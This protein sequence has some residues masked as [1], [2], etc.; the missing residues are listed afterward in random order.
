MTDILVTWN[1]ANGQQRFYCVYYK[2]GNNKFLDGRFRTFQ[3][4]Y[5]SCGHL[6]VIVFMEWA[7]MGRNR[8]DQKWK[9]GTDQP[10]WQIN[11]DLPFIPLND[12]SMD[13]DMTQLDIERECVFDMINILKEGNGTYNHI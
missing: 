12:N 13:G 10:H 5:C 4:A 9:S 1:R 7:Y 3:D 2:L 8:E 11:G 6:A